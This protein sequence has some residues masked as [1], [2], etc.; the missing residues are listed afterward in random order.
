VANVAEGR[1][2]KSFF[3]KMITR[4]ISLEDCILDLLDNSI[5][6]ARRQLRVHRR[7]GKAKNPLK[8]FEARLEIDSKK[9]QITDNCGGI[10]RAVAEHYAFRFGRV[11][12]SAPEKLGI[13]LYGVGMKR[14]I[15]KL[16][17]VG[18]VRSRLGSSGF[19]VKVDVAEWRDETDDWDFPLKVIQEATPAG[20]TVLIAPLWEEVGNVVG[21]PNFALGLRDRIACDYSFLI[22][23]GFTVKLNGRTV[24]PY[25]FAFR[26]GGGFTPMHTSEVIAGVT[27]EILAGFAEAPPDNVEAEDELVRKRDLSGWYIACND[28]IVI[29]ADKTSR[30]V[31]GRDDFTR[32]HPQ[33][34]GFLGI[35]RLRADDPR[36]LPWTTTKRDVDETSPVFRTAVERMKSATERCIQYTSSR[37]GDIDG[38]REAEGKARSISAL[39]VPMCRTPLFPRIV[40]KRKKGT[41]IHYNVTRGELDQALVLLEDRTLSNKEV[42]LQTFRFF[43]ENAE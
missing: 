25:P 33:Y 7:K 40:K 30:T 29:A 41:T 26:N 22:A 2:T 38:A 24:D 21:D 15:F 34:R 16:G 31:W 8:G 19:E 23:L 32:W 39:D 42:G 17:Q 35:V 12:A 6:G 37:R 18:S 3:V 13:G 11:E 10:P 43:L 9:C 28:R 14:A 20:T 36:L 4:D 5:D 1:P 27:V